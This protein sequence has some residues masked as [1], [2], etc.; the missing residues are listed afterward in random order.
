MTDSHQKSQINFQ[1]LTSMA[2]AGIK[3]LKCVLLFDPSKDT[4]FKGLICWKAGFATDQFGH[5]ALPVNH[6]E[7]TPGSGDETHLSF[8]HFGF[9]IIRRGNFAIVVNLECAVG[10]PGR[11]DLNTPWIVAGTASVASSQTPTSAHQSAFRIPT[12]QPADFPVAGKRPILRLCQ[13]VFDSAD[14]GL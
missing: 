2:F 14:I 13:N 7:A 10:M 8:I 1:L 3:L 4:R 5:A 9:H 11:K 6:P 12:E